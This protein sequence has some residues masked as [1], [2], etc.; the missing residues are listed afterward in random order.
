VGEKAVAV[1]AG[2]TPGPYRDHLWLS[3]DGLVTVLPPVGLDEH[4]VNLL[5]VD[6]PDLVAHRLNE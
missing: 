3:G 2:G 4:A 5:E 6:D 1:G